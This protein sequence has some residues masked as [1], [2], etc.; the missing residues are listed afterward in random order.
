MDIATSMK[1]TLIK[2]ILELQS[3]GRC[4]NKNIREVLAVGACGIGNAHALHV[5]LHLQQCEPRPL[6]HGHSL[7]QQNSPQPSA[8]TKQW[9]PYNTILLPL[10]WEEVGREG[11]DLKLQINC[12]FLRTLQATYVNKPCIYSGPF[13]P[14]IHYI[15]CSH[16]AADNFQRGSL[17]FSVKF[18][19]TTWCWLVQV[20]AEI[21]A[22]YGQ[23]ESWHCE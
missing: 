17:I 4:S 19:L 5:V 14:H 2:H 20:Y 21:W 10:Q 8:K 6:S 1:F 9:L 12:L 18:F 7:R 23:L 3:K 11:G 22:V 16:C 13:F 15:G